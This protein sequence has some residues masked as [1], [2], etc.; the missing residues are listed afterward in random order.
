MLYIKDLLP[1]VNKRDNFRWQ[2]LIRPTYFMPETK[3]IDDLPYDFR[4][5][6]IHTAIIV[7]KFG[8]ASGLVTIEDIIKETV[9]E[10]HDEYD[11]EERTYIISNDHT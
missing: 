11:D 10:A 9:G 4:A 5:N 2:S 7:N 6:K 1:H 3:I 8:G